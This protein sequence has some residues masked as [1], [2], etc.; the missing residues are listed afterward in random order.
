MSICPVRILSSPFTRPA[1]VLPPADDGVAFTKKET[2]KESPGAIVRELA[3]EP[4]SRN[5][6]WWF[7]SLVAA[8]LQTAVFDRKRVTRRLGML[9]W[10][11]QQGTY[12]A[13]ASA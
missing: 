3:P 1:V 7:V 11:Q 5:P 6:R 13:S 10:R 8:M 4:A 12:G 9:E 2:F